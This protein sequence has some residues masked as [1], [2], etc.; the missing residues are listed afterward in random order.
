[1]AAET[2]SRTRKTLPGS[3]AILI[4]AAAVAALYFGRDIFIPLAMALTLSFLLT[5][6]V[7]RLERLHLRRWVSVALVVAA[8]FLVLT[9]VGWVVA[10][11]LISVVNALPNYRDNIQDKIEAIHAPSSGPLAQTITS[12]KEISGSLSGEASGPTPPPEVEVPPVR[13]M[14][15]RELEREVTR[16]ETQTKTNPTPVMVVSP[17]VPESTYVRSLFLPVVKPLGTLAVVVVFTIYML[18]KRED[19]RNRTLLLAGVGRLN[20]MT[21]ALN[22]AAQRI[23]SFLLMNVLVNA[24]YG[25]VFGFGL[26]LL[27]VPNATLWGVLIGIL[28]MVPY[29][30]MLVA[31]S[32]TIVFTLAVF[33]GWWHPFFVVL[34]FV[35]LEIL[36]SN[37]IEPWLYGSHTGVSS[38]ALLATALVWTLLWG[39]AGLVLSTPLT[40]CLIVMGRHVPQFRFLHILLGDEATLAP[41]AAF[42]ERLLAMDQSEARAIADRFLE[43][44]NLVELYDGVLLPAL[45]L[46]EQ[47]RH[48]GNLDE[49]RGA[50]LF[51]SETELIAELTDFKHPWPPALLAGVKKG[52][53]GKSCPVVCIAASDQA[54]E[55]AATMLA[56]MLERSGRKTLLLPSSAI[57]TEIL[58]R[59]SL[60]NDTVVCISALPPF[61]FAHARAICQQVREH[62]PR[63]RIVVGLWGASGE[64]DAIRDRFGKTRP[65]AVVTTL[66]QALL[67]LM[68]C[69]TAPANAPVN[70]GGTETAASPAAV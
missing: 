10:A 15:R 17:P 38:L 54:D 45:V 66:Q 34:L 28:R 1:M 58:E 4:A 47:D 33:P 14:S 11:Q 8:S 39:W 70:G 43:G 20:V 55:V 48:K 22:D 60:E 30:G 69:E 26:Y 23:S 18:L 44:R 49:V 62:L 40:V 61:A 53:S 9:V 37:A 19:L 42:Y 32:A 3:E 57:S 31:G 56:Q 35:G 63:N 29:F 50:Y 65:N 21:Q 7:M 41:E 52:S 64:R 59:L 36:V 13:R 6:L 67:H 68:D 51:Q 12:I 25:V 24:G 2:L 16:L 27:H 5:P 46:A